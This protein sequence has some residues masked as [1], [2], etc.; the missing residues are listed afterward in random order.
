MVSGFILLAVGLLRLGWIVEV[1]PY[2][3]VS[4]FVTAASITVISTQFLVMMGIPNVNGREA[5]YKVI[6]STLRQLDHTRIDAAIGISCLI[7]LT[8]IRWVCAK[9]EVR[10]PHR[11]RLWATV[12]SLR[13]TFT[14]LLYILVSW[15]VNKN[16]STRRSRF[17]IVGHI[18]TGM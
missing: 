9:M 18:E 14:M 8:V 17:V 15:L 6:V 10:Q 4:A 7:L 2:I 3:P 1:I 16:L 11:K 5:P 12:S 13:L